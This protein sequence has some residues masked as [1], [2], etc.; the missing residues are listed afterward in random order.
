MEV[1]CLLYLIKLNFIHHYN[2]LSLSVRLCISAF[3]LPQSVKLCLS[4]D[5]FVRLPGFFAL[6]DFNRNSHLLSH[7]LKKEYSNTTLSALTFLMIR[8]TVV[9]FHFD[10]M[11]RISVY[12]CHSL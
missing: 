5:F 2:I 9:A 12:Q 4:C 7:H 11:K 10:K 6:L 3:S 8:Y 1:F